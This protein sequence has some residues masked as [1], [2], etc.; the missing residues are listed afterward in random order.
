MLTDKAIDDLADIFQEHDSIGG[1]ALSNP[2]L[3]VVLPCYNESQGIK[4]ILERFARFADEHDF[5]LILVD[6]GSTD[7]T[8]QVLASLL[9]SYSFA[10]CVR[11]AHNRGYGDGVY[12]G[13]RVA[14]GEVLAW[15]HADMQTD[16]GD[17]FR[18]LDVFQ[19][20]REAQRLIV[21]GRR[22]GRRLGER[23]ISRGMELVAMVLLRRWIPEINA[24]P[25]VFSRDVM[26]FVANPPVDFN[27]DVYVLFRAIQNGWRIHQI[28]VVFPPRQYGQSN[29]SATWKSKIRTIYQSMVFMFRLGMG[30]R[31]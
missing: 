13:L 22:H 25:K 29:W 4:N 21:K 26:E 31:A 19:N 10:R 8:P 17:V 16:P 14:R 6:N 18:A 24:Q 9:P 7:D 28:D 1:A 27:F 12:T 20:D 30:S 2:F 5:E 11:I 3:S 23:V 15:S